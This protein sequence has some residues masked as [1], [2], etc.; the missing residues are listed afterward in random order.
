VIC[1]MVGKA[2]ANQ[3]EER[4]CLAEERG[5]DSWCSTPYSYHQHRRPDPQSS[6]QTHLKQHHHV[7]S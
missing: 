1:V 5:C 4:H 3:M 2:K 7:L 6:M